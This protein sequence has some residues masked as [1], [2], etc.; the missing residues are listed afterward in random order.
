MLALTSG[1]ITAAKELNTNVFGTELENCGAK[2]MVMTWITC[3]DYCVHFDSLHQDIA[4]KM[5]CVVIPSFTDAYSSD[6]GSPTNFRPNFFTVT[7]QTALSEIPGTED[8]TKDCP[9][10]KWCINEDAFS[11]MWIM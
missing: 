9:V 6:D 7:G 8:A 2:G 4:S 5:V 3:T 1:L 10:Q 11:C